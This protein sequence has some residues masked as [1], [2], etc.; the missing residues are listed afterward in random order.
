MPVMTS[1]ERIY[2]RMERPGFPCDIASI[3]MLEPSPQAPLPFEQVRAVFA[4]R[5]HQSPLFT[6]LLAPAPLGIGEDRW[7]QAATVDIDAHVH[8]RQVPAPGDV[9]ALLATVLEVSKDPLERSR[10]LWQAWYLTGMADGG[11]ALLLRTHHAAIDGTGVLHLH[12]VLFDT[13]PTPVDPDQPLAPVQGRGCP[14]LLRRALYEVPTR[15]ATEVSTTR[16]IVEHASDA[17]PRTL[18]TKPSRAVRDPDTVHLPTLPGY[19]PSPTSHPPVTVFNQHVGD[20]SKV[21]AVISLPLEDVKQVRRAFP[22]V[23]INDILLTLVTGTLRE[24]LAATDDLPAGPLRT[25]CPVN[26]RP[27]TDQR[28]HGNHI[29]TMWIDLP[30]HL[31]DP[32]E[33]LRAVSANA[34]AAKAALPETRASWQALAD[35]EDLLLPGVVSA[36]M[37][38]AGTRVFGL[39]P[40]TQNLTVSTVPASTEPLY[41]A[42]RR[43]THMYARMITCPPIHLFFQALTYAGAIDFSITTVRQLCPDPQPLAD[44]LRAALDELTAL[45]L[46]NGLALN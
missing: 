3:F 26:L 44:G 34:T 31:A 25:T 27:P 32:A 28:A 13:Q 22:D 30:V 42:T 33:R 21:M 7:T 8:H 38:F 19:L 9:G 35:L 2:L 18:R 24:Y 45:R 5:R 16:H 40:P 11:A 4:Q 23:T 43:I 39:L 15:L 10:P 36:A 12:Q 14:S 29:T 20:P 37:A 6:H 1:T 41:L 46:G 17:L